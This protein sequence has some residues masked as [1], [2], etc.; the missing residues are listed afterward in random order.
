MTQELFTADVVEQ[1]RASG[2]PEA[3]PAEPQLVEFYRTELERFAECPMQA[4]LLSDGEVIDASAAMTGGQEIHDA[5]S[6]AVDEYISAPDAYTH[7]RDLADVI[8][9]RLLT[10]R[11]DVQ[12]DVLDAAWHAAYKVGEHL[13][14]I[15]NP[16]NIL[17]YDGGTGKRSGQLAVPIPSLGCIVS[18]ELDLVYTGASKKTLHATDWKS[19]R[20]HWSVT[21]VARSFQFGA[22]HPYL[23]FENYPEVDALEIEIATT[24]YGGWVQPVEFRRE[25]LD[26]YAARVYKAAEIAMVC[27]GLPIE[28][29]PCWPEREKCAGCPAAARCRITPPESCAA[30][31][32]AFVLSMHTLKC[33]LAAMTDEASAYVATHGPIEYGGLAFGHKPAALKKSKPTLFATGETDDAERETEH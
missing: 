7:A 11:P 27:R 16:A 33:A 29:V 20:Q 32:G 24:R 13:R 25:H 2:L 3:A 5:Y 17:H 23:V 10:S 30:D 22:M 21:S 19:G 12:P 18:A 9:G 1:A 14:E 28:K 26:R 31:P 8:K 15:G 4:R 6:L